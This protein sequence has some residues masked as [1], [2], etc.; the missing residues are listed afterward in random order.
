MPTEDQVA[1]VLKEI[2][3]PHTGMSIYEMGL[4]S[5]ISV[6]DDRVGLTFRP[7]SAFCPLGIH[8]AMNIKRRLAALDGVKKVDLVVV[9]HIHE[10]M[11][12]REVSEA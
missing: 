11:I 1:N 8:F 6:S 4:I 9:G 10:D 3:D 12:N 7:T 5:N 2:M